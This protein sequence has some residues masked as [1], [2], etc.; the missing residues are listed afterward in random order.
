MNL[1]FQE[2]EEAG[3]PVSEE[4][5]VCTL[6]QNIR[7]PE[8]LMTVARVDGSGSEMSFE[9]AMNHLTEHVDVEKQSKAV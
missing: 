9:A 3:E 1:A 8:L 4:K 2:L 6:T 7:T 5:K